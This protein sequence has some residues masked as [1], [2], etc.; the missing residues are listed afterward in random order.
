MAIVEARLKAKGKE[1]Q[2]SV[3]VDEALK[4]RKGEGNVS[5]ALNM[6][7]IYTDVKKGE[8]ASN[9]ELD[10]A[11]GTTDVFTIAEKIMKDGEILKPQEYRD[12][13]REARVKKVIDLIL[14]NAVDQHGNPYTEDRIRK[15]VDEVHYNFDN[16]PAEAQMKDLVHKLKEVIPIK[17]DTKKVRLTIP[18]QFT[19]QVYGMLK[20][21]MESEDWL[22]N[23]D[24]QVILNIPA[25]MQIDFYEKLNGVTHGAVQSEEL[26]D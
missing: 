17:I 9:D 23:G 24:L 15:A 11:F 7:N 4:V 1:Y 5:A 21:Y 22:S 12:A 26:G 6:N 10:N 2:I 13:E 18:A 8:V 14:R 25:G 16:R 19:G 3:D 20:D